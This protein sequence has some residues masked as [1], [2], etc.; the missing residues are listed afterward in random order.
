MDR[1]REMRITWSS[2]LSEPKAILLYGFVL[3]FLVLGGD[4][5]TGKMVLTHDAN[6]WYGVF[7]YSILSVA[8]GET[9]LWDPYSLNGAPFY[10]ANN[11]TGNLDPSIIIF[12]PLTKF[13][14]ALTLYHWNYIFKLLFCWI[15][16]YLLYSQISK[17]R[18]SSA[19]ASGLCFLL[20]VPNTLFQNGTM[21]PVIYGPWLIWSFLKATDLETIDVNSRQRFWL[22]TYFFAGLSIH[23][24]LPS[25][26]YVFVLIVATTAIGIHPQRWRL[27]QN[28]F[29]DNFSRRGFCHFIVFILLISPFLYAFYQLT[30]PLGDYFN[31]HRARMLI[32]ADS[33]VL[34]TTSSLDVT[35]SVGTV[36]ST[37]HQLFGMFFQIPDTRY[38]VDTKRITL[39]MTEHFLTLGSAG[40]FLFVVALVTG[41][42]QRTFWIFLIPCVYI[43]L[44]MYLP[45]GSAALAFLQRIP[46]ASAIHINYNFIFFFYI[47][48]G[49]I[50][51][52]GISWLRH[53][54]QPGLKRVGITCIA[55][56]LLIQ[57]GVITYYTS[58]VSVNGAAW[59]VNTVSREFFTWTMNEAY[60]GAL[61][62]AAFLSCVGFAFVIK[63]QRARQWAY[64]AAIVVCLHN[65]VHSLDK[66]KPYVLQSG[67][68]WHEGFIHYDR[69]FEYVERR[70][71]V[72][73]LFAD[74]QGFT[75]SLFR[76]PA[77]SAV[78]ANPYGSFTRRTF[79][80]LR[81]VS[82]E[83]QNLLS[84]L[85]G[86]RYGFFTSY[87]KS[88]S[89]E[90]SLVLLQKL[91]KAELQS[92]IL[93][94]NA[95]L[96]FDDVEETNIDIE[97][98]ATL[99]PVG[100]REPWTNYYQKQVTLEL[101]D[102]LDVAHISTNFDPDSIGHY[103]FVL[104]PELTQFY[105][106]F[107][108]MPNVSLVFTDANEFCYRRVHDWYLRSA[109]TG[110][111]P[112]PL[113][114]PKERC[115]IEFNGRLLN[116]S[117]D[118]RSPLITNELGEL[119]IV[120]Q[121][122]NTITY[123]ELVDDEASVLPTNGATISVE[124]FSPNQILFSVTT[125]QSGFFYYADS[126]SK[127]WTAT[128]NGAPTQVYP[129]NVAFKSIF[130]PAGTHSVELVYKPRGY[131]LIFWLFALTSLLVGMLL[132]KY[133]LQY[134]NHSGL[135]TRAHL[136]N[137]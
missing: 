30:Q 3:F 73:P 25:Y 119:P 104:A 49:G 45:Y 23:Q 85:G 117:D 55:S 9:P 74:T 19:L 126:Y 11:M 2:I 120:D 43:A 48:L 63:N 132:I 111:Y 78:E 36:Q 107:S 56:T 13:V 94:E 134:R 16:I 131:R 121:P 21:L 103:H 39:Q 102:E 31:F 130:L 128:I 14:S 69:Q 84:G 12:A 29:S 89:V 118:L 24:Y 106:I 70:V 46:T 51:V 98:G 47:C 108:Y 92:V 58:Q 76:L 37:L 52:V 18:F 62:F 129:S 67:V 54:T 115:D 15:G 136:G 32:P 5:L 64:I 68:D 81:F 105:K 61:W 114:Q 122:P 96:D 27:I 77:S 28:I 60:G 137:K 26:T 124:D 66:I 17:D 50:W 71:P 7:A 90:D 127:D 135:M 125:P 133:S 10:F 123:L 83:K 86:P 95:T 44:L 57:Y 109:R 20:V 40:L 97:D 34:A 53:A 91:T 93:L 79:D 33:T 59:S 6:H 88:D 1:D 41:I 42:K 80:Y 4:I 112:G 87:V 99:D 72:L 8:R 82:H 65:V 100:A 110:F 22:S 116:I 38:F 75:G 101:G 35:Q 113:K